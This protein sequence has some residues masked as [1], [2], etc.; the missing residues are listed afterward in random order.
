MLSMIGLVGGLILLTVLAL[1]GWNLF[2]AAPFCALIV[3]LTGGLQIFPGPA[4]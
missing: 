1:R 3:G 2:I 4:Q